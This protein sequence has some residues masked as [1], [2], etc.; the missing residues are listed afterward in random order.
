SSLNAN[1]SVLLGN[2]DGT[3]Q[4]LPKVHV[5]G[6]RRGMLTVSLN[7]NGL[8]DLVVT[9][10]TLNNIF[11]PAPENVIVLQA[12]KD[13]LGMLSFLPLPPFSSLGNSPIKIVSADFNGD[14]IPDLAVAA[15][16]YVA[17]LLGGTDPMGNWTVQQ[18]VQF[19]LTVNGFTG[20]PTD[21]LVGKFG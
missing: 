15:T 5:L 8:T 3:F 14:G 6:L 18:R 2:G 19:N 12:Q 20:T 7:N 10:R 11:P 9:S 17:V 16:G 1:V 21:I 4:L 13:P